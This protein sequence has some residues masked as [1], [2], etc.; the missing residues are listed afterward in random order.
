MPLRII[1]GVAQPKISKENLENIKIPLLPESFQLQIEKIVK[2]AHEKQTQA[3]QLYKQ[4]EQILL[5]ELQLIN[6]KPK[7]ILTFETTANKIEKA[8]RIDADYF[9]PKYQE[10]I[11]KIENYKGGWDFVG[12]IVKW[13]K[14]IE[15]GTKAY[16]EQGKEFVRVSDFSIF[17]I[18]KTSK[19]ISEEHFEEIKN[20]FQPQKDEILFTKDGTIGISYVLKENIDGVL[21]SAFLRLTLK[22]EY[23]N[24]EK[25]TLALI[26][27]SILSKLQI[28]Q[29]SGGAII[30]HLT[31]SDFEKLKIPII[32]PRIQE[33]IAEK[34]SLSHK[35]RKE[36]KNLLEQAKKRVETEIEKNAGQ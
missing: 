19:K 27:N 20:G 9:Q 29:L 8:V 16:T 11:K 30:A 25:E 23:K 3:K 17:G 35:L 26:L 5:E 24:F 12:N 2:V 34:I 36:S 22:R 28:E 32:P 15:P 33:K 14:G 31:P 7:H 18:D 10:I 4:A 1:T 13:K 6:Y 21:S